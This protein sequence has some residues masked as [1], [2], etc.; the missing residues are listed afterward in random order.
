MSSSLLAFDDVYIDVRI[1]CK[2]K[3][4]WLSVVIGMLNSHCRGIC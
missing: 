2:M 4:S 1:Q 3:L